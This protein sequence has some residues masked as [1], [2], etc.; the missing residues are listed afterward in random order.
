MIVSLPL[1]PITSSKFK[2]VS[3]PIVEPV[4]VVAL[5]VSFAVPSPT[6]SFELIALPRFTI[7]LV[8]VFAKDNVSWVPVL[9][10][11]ILL[12]VSPSIVSLSWVPIIFSISI[13]VW[14]ADVAFPR[15]TPATY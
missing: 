8:E 11:K 14:S 9:A 2:T 15:V 6:K 3:V 10:S 1:P 4:A 13:K 5:I 12:A 7:V